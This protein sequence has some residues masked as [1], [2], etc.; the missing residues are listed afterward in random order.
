VPLRLF[1]IDNVVELDTKAE[2]GTREERR[3]AFVE[4][5]RDA[6]Y[7]S[8]RTVLD[9]LLR[10]FGQSGTY[11]PH[12]SPSFLAG[13]CAMFTTEHGISGRVGELYPEVILAF[14]LNFPIAIGEI[15][16]AGT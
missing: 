15:V 7:A 4:M 12:E 10:E 13:R 16:L 8:V 9:A 11:S 2:T 5:G 14:G 6:G 1:E 3:L